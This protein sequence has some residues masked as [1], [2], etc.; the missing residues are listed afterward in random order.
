MWS[1]KGE[2]IR[3][4]A[5]EPDDLDFLYELENNTDVWE[6]SGTTTPYSRNILKRYL[7]HAH[8]DIY[9]VKQ[10]RLCICD[11]TE[12]AV[13]LIDLFDFDPKNR[14]AGMGIIVLDENRRNKGFGAEAI[15][16]LTEYAFSS[17]SLRQVYAN[18]IE[19]NLA[20]M[21][22]FE[23]MGF[24]KVGIK[25]D[26]VFSEGTYKDEVLFQKLNN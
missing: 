5:L 25:K 6:I 15:R 10:L 3:L 11:E 16:L 8:R 12:K 7:D 2:H 18:V 20:S 13:G 17:L 1:L 23:K 19:G 9:E 4:R 14:R 24:E 26:W 22:L 21:H